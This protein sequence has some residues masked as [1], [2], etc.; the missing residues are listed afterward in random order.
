MTHRKM[1]IRSLKARQA[2]WATV[3][4]IPSLL[5]AS[6]AVSAAESDSKDAFQFF[7][8]DRY[9][10]DDNLFRVPDGAVNDPAVTG[11]ESEDDYVNRA[12]A[13]VRVRLD[14]SRQV[15]HADLRIDDVRYDR[16][17][18]LDHTGGSADLLW[19]WQLG[20]PLSG[21]F[22]GTYDRAQASL[23]NYRYFQRDIVETAAYGAEV[24]YAL[25]SRWRLLAL[26][27][28]VDTE[29]GALDRQLENFE[30]TTG[31]GGIEYA[32][33]AGTLIALEYKFTDG[34]FPEAEALAGAPR[35][36]KDRV[37]GVR[38]VLPFTEKTRLLVRAGYFDRDYD[39]PASGDYSGGIYN[40]TLQWEPRAKIEFDFKAWHELR[41][42]SDAE[43]DYFEADGFSITPKWRPRTK[44]ELS[45]ALS[46]ENQDYLGNSLILDPIEEAGREDTMKSALVSIDYTPRD[47]ISLGLAYRWIDRESNRQFRDYGVNVLSAEFK[48]TF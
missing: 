43:S 47:L 13:G 45:A 18:D 32:T 21:K 25:G 14:Q 10:Y 44:L 8:M 23:N 27:A 33:P 24:R 38:V 19:D 22:F 15:F 48:L 12:S 2:Q 9:L 4:C 36:Y 35:G 6:G 46:Y 20:K 31:G 34:D 7:V 17:D 42:Y 26:G 30:S 3:A 5:L 39:N 37:P 41:A 40:A 29:H 16:N 11:R 28:R 1:N